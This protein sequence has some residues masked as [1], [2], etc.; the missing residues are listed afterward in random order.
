MLASKARVARYG[1]VDVNNKCFSRDFCSGSQHKL[2]PA[3]EDIM[4]TL[5][6][7]GAPL[8]RYVQSA[9]V[10]FI[11]LQYLYY[12]VSI[13]PSSPAPHFD[14]CHIP[15][16]LR[17]TALMRALL[18]QENSKKNG[19]SKTINVGKELGVAAKKKSMHGNILHWAVLYA[20]LQDAVSLEGNCF[21]YFQ[22]NSFFM[23][24]GCRP[25]ES[26]AFFCVVLAEESSQ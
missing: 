12:R 6:K 15:Y 2:L 3:A 21:Q 10:L 20:F 22:C 11:Y 1:G 8:E 24:N 7:L 18:H 16:H 9:P 17:A 26:E 14:P 19:F 13:L 23:A 4:R 25:T 5:Y